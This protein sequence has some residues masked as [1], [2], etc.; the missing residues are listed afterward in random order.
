MIKMNVKVLTCLLVVTL[1]TNG[2]LSQSGGSNPY[3]VYYSSNCTDEVLHEFECCH[4]PP[5]I[6][7]SLAIEYITRRMDSDSKPWQ[8]DALIEWKLSENGNHSFAVSFKPTVSLAE[9]DAMDGSFVNTNRYRFCIPE[10][11]MYADSCN[12]EP[13]FTTVVNETSLL[14]EDILFGFSYEFLLESVLDGKPS[15]SYYCYKSCNDVLP[16]TTAPDCY[17]ATGDEDFCREYPVPISGAPT[18]VEIG[19]GCPTNKQTSWEITLSWD[20]PVHQNGEILQYDIR[21][22]RLDRGGL[23]VFWRSNFSYLAN[24]DNTSYVYNIKPDDPYIFPVLGG[25]QT[26]GEYAIK[27]FTVVR[28]PPEFNATYRQRGAE[29]IRILRTYESDWCPTTPKETPTTPTAAT[30]P[31][32]PIP[33]SA[34]TQADSLSQ[35]A[36]PNLA[37]ES[38]GS[39]DTVSSGILT[40]I[41]LVSLLLFVTFVFLVNRAFCQGKQRSL[42]RKETVYVQKIQNHYEMKEQKVIVPIELKGKEITDRSNIEVE[43]EPLGRGQYGDVYKGTLIGLNGMKDKTIVAVKT[44]KCDASLALKE[45]FVDEIKLM[46]DIGNH[47]H[48]MPLYGCCT[49]TEPYYLITEFMKYGG[50]DKFLRRCRSMEN[51]IIDPIYNLKELNQVQIAWQIS[52][53]MAFLST[54]KFFHGDLA[55]R[56]CL[57]G[58]DLVV[59]ISDFGLSDDVYQSGYKRIAPE[60]KRPVKWYSPEANLDGVCSSKGDVWSYGIVMWEIYSLGDIPY[61]G[62]PAT[63]VVKRILKG[64]RLPQPD[65]CPLDIYK[66]MLECWQ[67]SPKERPTFSELEYALELILHHRADQDI[68]VTTGELHENPYLPVNDQSEIPSVVRKDSSLAQ[69]INLSEMLG[70]SADSAI[71]DMNNTSTASFIVDNSLVG[72]PISVQPILEETLVPS[73]KRKSTGSFDFDPELLSNESDSIVF[74]NIFDEEREDGGSEE[75]ETA[76][77]GDSDISQGKKQAEKA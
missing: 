38:G 41:V 7:D 55:A 32:T 27:I 63:E 77:K 43:S 45:D 62:M 65:G 72:A 11:E 48:I 14:V 12:S 3:F 66:I 22:Y 23:P 2:V 74:T 37:T 70:T 29:S 15:I 9:L 57:V 54:T 8:L 39:P 50:L 69:K 6:P 47:P 58:A 34:S 13:Y 76:V 56:N 52:K 30:T 26:N 18:N 64:Y 5:I 68:R 42:D 20:P 1:L 35:S 31:T 71:Y 28:L 36:T 24:E 60:K 40:I 51:A 10:D 44:P 61:P 46:I 16:E 33:R 53:G 49:I 73:D 19:A 59:K 4:R 17:E 67:Q 25:F 21:A 75:K